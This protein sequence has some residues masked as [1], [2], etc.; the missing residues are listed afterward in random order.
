M[1]LAV[2]VSTRGQEKIENTN[3]TIIISMKNNTYFKDICSF[4]LILSKIG[5][6]KKNEKIR[7]FL[8]QKIKKYVIIIIQNKRKRG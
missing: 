6:S 1:I 4:T 2:G 7:Q 8:L 5:I 3:A